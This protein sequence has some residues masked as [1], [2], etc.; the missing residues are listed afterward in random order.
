[1]TL[2]HF[3]GFDAEDALLK[4]LSTLGAA[5]D[6]TNVGRYGT[7][8]AIKASTSSGRL[9]KLITAS[10]QIIAAGA[11]R[12]DSIAATRVLVAGWADTNSVQHA[13]LQVSTSGQLQAC[14]AGVVLASSAAGLIVAGAWNFIEMRA[15]IADAAGVIE[16]KLNGVQ[17]INFSGDT[18]NAGTATNF[19]A[20]SICSDLNV[21][22]DDFYVLNSSGSA[23]QNTFLGEVVVQTLVPNAAGASTQ[24][25]P[26]GSATNYEN[27]D[28]L[29][30]SATDYNASSTVGHK[31][32]YGLS[33]L[34][35][36]TGTIFGVQANMIASKTG[37]GAAGLRS[38]VRSGGTDYPD[39]SQALTA[40]P[41]WYGAIRET[42]P[43]TAVA[44]TASGVNA[45]E[46][47]AE[48]V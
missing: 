11:I 45:L 32:S 10:A 1:M 48:V 47:G 35:A 36:A 8:K 22:Y 26:V 18:K 24:F 30:Y 33:N 43:A 3:D 20:V 27:V 15:T 39:A 34:D 25:T 17:V 41:A 5:P 40:T 9:T 29:P 46:V 2:L 13:T 37:I 31:D 38:L 7:G 19:D 28:E 44:W 4:W 16:V 23:P 21:V 42:D 12:V 6:F 14:R